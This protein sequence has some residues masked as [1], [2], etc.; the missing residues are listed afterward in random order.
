MPGDT[1]CP[2]LDNQ[3]ITT[4]YSGATVT[5][6]DQVNRIRKS[7]MDAF[8][9]ILSITEQDP[10]TGGLSVVTNY[11]YDPVD[12]LTQV[13][14]GGQVRTFTYDALARMTSRTTPEGGTE[15]FTYNDAGAPLKRKDARGV[16][17]HYGYDALNRSN[18]VW[19]TGS[20]GD[21]AGSVRPSLP[22]G[23]V[24]SNDVTITYNTASPGNGKVN[25]LTDQVGNE[26]Y[27][28]DSLTRLQSKT[29]TLD[30]RSYT[31]QYIY[32]TA[33]QVTTFVYPVTRH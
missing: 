18:K 21:D 15:T 24:A 33:G 3:L 4:A 19:Y 28:Y 30:T 16:E 20:G 14:Q 31:T 7:Q 13:N 1:T 9:R 10:T 23:V 6:T 29:R 8:G 11:T 17:T 5:V 22:A 12:N 25:Q 2:V 26:S 27:V 32:N